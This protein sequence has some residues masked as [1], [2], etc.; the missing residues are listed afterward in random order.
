MFTA[1]VG[2]GLTKFLG[3]EGG[4]REDTYFT[5]YARAQYTFSEKLSVGVT[6]SYFENWSTL[7]FSDFYRDSITFDAS[8]RF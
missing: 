2:A 1:G 7:P 3:D 4:D 5:A 6:Y 8:S